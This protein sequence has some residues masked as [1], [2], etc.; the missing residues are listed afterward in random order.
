MGLIPLGLQDIHYQR[1][2]A[3][4]KQLLQR[5]STA[6]R[7]P[8][9]QGSVE[10]QAAMKADLNQV[11]YALDKL[12]SNLVRI[13]VFGLVSRGKSA[14]VNAL[15]GQR[16]VPTGPLHGVTQFPRSIYWSL[17]LSEPV[18]VELIDTPGLDEVGGQS[19]AAMALEVAHD[20]DLILFVIAGDMTRT[21]YRA[22]T[23]LQAAHKPLIVVFNK[24]D[25]YPDQDRQAI[26]QRLQDLFDASGDV[27]RPRLRPED[28]VRVAAEPAQMQVRVEWEDGRVTYEWE[29][30]PPN[31]TEL[32]QKLLAILNQE[33]KSLLALNALRQARESEQSIARKALRL[34][35]EAAEEL[36][37]KFA[38]WKAI[39]I[40][41]N[42]IAVVDILGGFATDLVMI[43]ALARLY[44]LPMTRHEAG[45][46]LNSILW[47]AGG[48]LA[49]EVGS[50]LLLGVGKSASAAVSFFDGV[51]GV[52]AYGSAAIAQATLAG[53]G[54]YR[55]GKAAQVYLE[56]G[57]TWGPEGV[58]TVLHNI[59]DQVDR[60]TVLYRLRRELEE[61][62]TVLR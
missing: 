8:R 35:Q 42:P 31:I 54:S 62:V 16:L 45:K 52:M 27:N 15:V 48:V 61:K 50:G 22:L 60:D 11:S 21:E 20:A 18:T 10:L 5:Y 4:L 47:S 29:A 7:Q 44:G 12:N 39:A 17:E 1:A 59:L 40:G 19:R 13:A 14:V 57:C 34:N 38:Q 36:I 23:E 55:V 53:Y 25:L 24:T 58:N 28:I 46:L 41:L 26:Y 43:R 56:Q 9:R 6:M 33:G 32:K 2:K 37:W 49:G 30:P 3:S 51:S